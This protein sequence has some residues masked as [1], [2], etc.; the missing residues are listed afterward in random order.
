MRSTVD[1][2]SVR[3]Q[4]ETSH[5]H[6]HTHAAE[7]FA[8]SHRCHSCHICLECRMN[9][10]IDEC[11]FISMSNAHAVHTLAPFPLIRRIVVFFFFWEMVDKHYCVVRG[12]YVT[13]TK[14]MDDSEDDRKKAF[15][16]IKKKTRGERNERP[17]RK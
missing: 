6:T 14:L 15:G 2:H 1:T 17:N 12:V 8:F 3:T 5:T 13:R 11:H 4:I 7:L 9:H 16:K 10:A